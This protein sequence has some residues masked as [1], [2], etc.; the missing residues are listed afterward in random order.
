MAWFPK[1][2]EKLVR[3]QTVQLRVGA[4]ISQAR[5]RSRL[6][7]ARRKTENR[8]VK[9]GPGIHGGHSDAR[10]LGTQDGH[11]LSKPD[12]AAL[13]GKIRAACRRQ[14]IFALFRRPMDEK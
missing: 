2:T 14:G 3:N 4:V 9:D 10:W 6:T 8:D 11:E 5:E 7:L 1:H 12:T 13:Q